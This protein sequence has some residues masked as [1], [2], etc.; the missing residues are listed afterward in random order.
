[1]KRLLWI[2]FAVACMALRMANRAHSQEPRPLLPTETTTSSAVAE[3][4]TL[5][6]LQMI[7]NR[8]GFTTEWRT[9]PSGARYIGIPLQHERW[10]FTIQ[11]SVDNRNGKIYLVI[12]LTNEVERLPE[13]RM[14]QLLTATGKMGSYFY[15]TGSA[16]FLSRE[17]E[18][19]A[20]SNARLQAQISGLVAD[21]ARTSSLWNLAAPA[22]APAPPPAPAAPKIPSTPP[23]SPTGAATN[24]NWHSYRSSEGKF[25]V[26]MPA[27]PTLLNTDLPTG[28]F[29]TFQAENRGIGVFVGYADLPPM[30]IAGK[31]ADEIFRN[32]RNGIV[33]SKL[34]G[35]V[36]SER[37]ITHAGYPAREYAFEVCGRQVE[38]QT[39]LVEERLYVLLATCD[40]PADPAELRTF[41]NSFQLTK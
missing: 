27:Q 9:A 5:E 36:L 10:N 34:K 23:E 6:K 37:T 7:A 32:A 20:C 13:G 11:S 14:R 24:N 38:C 2:L 1:M 35:R 4:F 15:V 28:K 39:V 25:R 3:D 22:A 26:L 33:E 30:A 41:F 8:S 19:T 18:C 40:A 12:C 29:F 17:I 21:A 31:E 16:L